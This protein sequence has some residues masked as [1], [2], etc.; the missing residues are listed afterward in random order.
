M[1]R[2]SITDENNISYIVAGTGNICCT[3]AENL[4]DVSSN[5]LRWYV[6][7]ENSHNVLPGKRI[8]G[9]FSSISVTKHAITTS[10]YDQDGVLLH[11]TSPLMPRQISK[12]L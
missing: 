11:T 12:N 5:Y 8:T 7:E 3:K 10:F 4:D 9:G 1:Y 2:E 6:S